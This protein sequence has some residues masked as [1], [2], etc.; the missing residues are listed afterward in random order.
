MQTG[1]KKEQFAAFFSNTTEWVG[2]K[3]TKGRR[4]TFLVLLE[5][6][7]FLLH[8]P[9]SHCSQFFF[10]NSIIKEREKI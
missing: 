2:V 10:L 6:T 8:H 7:S 1:P 4:L 3:G 5:A 9:P